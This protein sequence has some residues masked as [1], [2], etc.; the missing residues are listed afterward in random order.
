MVTE[1]LK[2]DFDKSESNELHAELR[3]LSKQPNVSLDD[4]LAHSFSTF[5]KFIGDNDLMSKDHKNG[6]SDSLGLRKSPSY[7]DI[8]DVSTDSPHVDEEGP[9]MITRQRN[10]TEFAKI[11]SEEYKE[12]RTRLEIE[13]DIWFSQA[14]PY[15]IDDAEDESDVLSI[16]G[17]R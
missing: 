11:L 5:D 3:T 13:R 14:E 1:I 8:E 15:D 10:P 17:T 16:T 6:R 9:Q 4:S 2:S 7:D 12:P